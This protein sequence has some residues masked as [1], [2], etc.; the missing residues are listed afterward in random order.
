MVIQLGTLSGRGGVGEIQE[1][2]AGIQ[3]DY[4]KCHFPIP[5]VSH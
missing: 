2:E 4:E 5:K 3:L 1:Q